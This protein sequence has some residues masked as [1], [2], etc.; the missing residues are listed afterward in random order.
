MCR[1]G[2]PGV[3][4]EQDGPSVAQAVYSR[5]DSFSDP[6]VQQHTAMLLYARCQHDLTPPTAETAIM[7]PEQGRTAQWGE[8]SRHLSSDRHA[9]S[10]I[11][12]KITCA[13]HHVKLE[14][15]YRTPRQCMEQLQQ[16]AP[17]EKCHRPHSIHS[18]ATHSGHLT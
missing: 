17:G 1:G 9:P 15:V 16:A 8:S 7:K 10:G 12:S 18:P 11:E 14:L 6:V 2:L 4:T 3:R 5:C 13:S